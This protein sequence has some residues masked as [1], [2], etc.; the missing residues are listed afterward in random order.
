VSHPWP[1]FD[2]AVRTPLLEL[3]IPT[4]EMLVGLA[5][6]ITAGIHEPSW[7]P[8]DDPPWTDESSPDRERSWMQR[9]W[10]ARTTITPGEWRLRFAVV[11]GG[12]AVGMQD[13]FATSFP[14]LRTVATY[15][16]LGQRHQGQGIGKEMRAAVLHLAFEGFGAQRAASDAFD[17][18]LASAGV[19]RALGYAENGREWALR[20]GAAAPMQRFLLTREEW[21]PRRRDDI[22]LVGVEACQAL[23]GL[24]EE[25]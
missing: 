6:V 20:R 13:L 12:R 24:T 9:Q 10:G 15:S 5:G 23:L 4:D 25:C 22:S 14:A 16:W 17:D 3:R 7:M 19:S 11:L 21:P 8:F 2:L 1:F 18:N